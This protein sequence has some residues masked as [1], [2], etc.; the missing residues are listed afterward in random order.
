MGGG[1]EAGTNGGPHTCLCE[2]PRAR[3]RAEVI[4]KA[5]ASQTGGKCEGPSAKPVGRGTGSKCP[6]L[7]GGTDFLP[8][9]PAGPEIARGG[10]S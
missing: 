9:S 10:M 7:A 5:G 4:S 6:S 3:G 8:D 1:V 2:S